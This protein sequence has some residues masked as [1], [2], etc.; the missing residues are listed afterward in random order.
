MD[1]F[2]KNLLNWPEGPKRIGPVLWFFLSRFF[3]KWSIKQGQFPLNFIQW[4]KTPYE[5][6]HK[7]MEKLLKSIQLFW[8]PLTVKLNFFLKSQSKL[9]LVFCVVISASGFRTLL[10]TYQTAL[11]DD[12]YFSLL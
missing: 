8:T 1:H 11:S 6:E 10:L 7:N 12:F 2:G 5:H 4:I 3:P 9:V